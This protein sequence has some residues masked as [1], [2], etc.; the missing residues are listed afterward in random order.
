MMKSGFTGSRKLAKVAFGALALG[1]VAMSI[2]M[3]PIGRGSNIAIAV[4]LAV[5]IVGAAGLA[6][7]DRLDRRSQPSSRSSGVALLL[8]WVISITAFIAGAYFLAAP[9]LLG[10]PS[11][12][13][14]PYA[15]VELSVGLLG[16]ILIPLL[17]IEGA[18]R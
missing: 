12:P 6:F 16:I 15:V 2:F 18:Q 4:V 1:G 13:M 3:A 10:L 14:L 17:K 8:A 9:R 5:A 11:N 7:L